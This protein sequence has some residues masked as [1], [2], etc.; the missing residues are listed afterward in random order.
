MYCTF[1]YNSRTRTAKHKAY[2]DGIVSLIPELRIEKCSSRLGLQKWGK[3]K[4]RQELI[5]I[6]WI[7]I[8]KGSMYQYFKNSKNAFPKR[9]GLWKSMSFWIKSVLTKIIAF[10]IRTFLNKQLSSVQQCSI[11]VFAPGD[12]GS[13]PV[14]VVIFFA[15]YYLDVRDLLGTHKL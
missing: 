13:H 15:S 10:C 3:K 1:S 12:L 9:M 14:G 4:R 6:T 8:Y 5:L 11:L 2:M 7:L